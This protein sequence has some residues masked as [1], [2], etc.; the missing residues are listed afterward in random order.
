MKDHMATLFSVFL[1]IAILFSIVAASIYYFCQWIKTMWCTYIK[2][3]YTMEYYSAV[4]KNEINAICS[5]VDGPQDYH[6][7]RSNKIKTNIIS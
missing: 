5:N 6:I 3:I 2:H 1:G 4:H 7:R